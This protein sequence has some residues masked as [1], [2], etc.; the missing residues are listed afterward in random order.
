MTGLQ[1]YVALSVNLRNLPPEAW[2]KRTALTGGNYLRVQYQLG[3]S[4][5]AGGIEWRFM[6]KDKV[7]GAV[8]C[9]Y[10]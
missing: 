3:L 6:Y 1:I 8:D 10:M 7:I 4:F 2:Q 9:Q 5:G